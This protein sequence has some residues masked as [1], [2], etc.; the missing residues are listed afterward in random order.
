MENKIAQ[1]WM[2][3]VTFVVISSE[4]YR[5]K[6][7]KICLLSNSKPRIVIISMEQIQVVQILRRTQCATV[8]I[9]PF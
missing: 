5:K 1:I 2:N 4:K 8:V 7:E 9:L 6:I 3:F